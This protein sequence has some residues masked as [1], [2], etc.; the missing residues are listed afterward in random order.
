MSACIVGGFRT[1]R[2]SDGCESGIIVEVFLCV[3]HIC[4][5]LMDFFNLMIY[6]SR[7]LSD[8]KSIWIGQSVKPISKS[9]DNISDASES[10]NF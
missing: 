10:E 7:I 2:C 5:I 1:R 8:Q 3:F 6:W 4:R 9:N